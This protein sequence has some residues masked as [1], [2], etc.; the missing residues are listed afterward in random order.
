MNVPV[1]MDNLTE[2]VEITYTEEELE[3]MY[4]EYEERVWEKFC[5]NK[6]LQ[7]GLRL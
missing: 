5:F 6:M 4:K 1:Y 2:D 3:G 7:K